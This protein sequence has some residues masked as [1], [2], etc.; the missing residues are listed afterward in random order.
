LQPPGNNAA[1]ASWSS[2]PA[3]ASMG[4]DATAKEDGDRKTA[5]R[6]R[7]NSTTPDAAVGSGVLVWVP[8]VPAWVSDV[9]AWVLRCSGVDLRCSGVGS[10]VFRRGS[11]V[12]RRGFSGVS[13]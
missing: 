10:P 4:R 12:F 8:G 1:G 9:P 5:I 3:E 2:G 6:A 13:A 11:P 7:K